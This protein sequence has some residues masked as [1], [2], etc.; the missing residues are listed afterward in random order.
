MGERDY[1]KAASYVAGT[2]EMSDENRGELKQTLAWIRFTTSGFTGET[3]DN[4]TVTDSTAKASYTKRTTDE[5]GS[6]SYSVE[7]DLKKEAAGG[8]E[9][10]SLLTTPPVV[11]GR[12]E[13]KHTEPPRSAEGVCGLWSQQRPL[14]QTGVSAFRSSSRR[15]LPRRAA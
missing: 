8:V 3:F 4:V 1:D 11:T 6:F 9:D 13:A 10:R 14:R 7:L 2:G 15:S 5:D 12:D